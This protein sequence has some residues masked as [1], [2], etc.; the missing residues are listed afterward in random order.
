MKTITTVIILFFI[1][2]LLSCNRNFI[3]KN[4]ISDNTTIDTILAV[5]SLNFLGLENH[6]T[7]TKEIAHSTLLEYFAKRNYYPEEKISLDSLLIYPVDEDLPMC[8]GFDTLYTAHLN[9]D[10]ILDGIISY[11]QMPCGASGSCYLPH[12]AIITKIHNKYS[13]INIDF[14]PDNYTIDSISQ[15][16]DFTLIHGKVYDCGIH[17]YTKPYKVSIKK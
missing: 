1:T 17:E 9:K 4:T 16:K 5:D 10:K 12:V 13:I 7:L 14:I 3:T 8:I 15:D 11:W 6:E 2:I